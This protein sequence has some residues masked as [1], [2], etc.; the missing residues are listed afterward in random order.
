M[1]DLSGGLKM[2]LKRRVDDWVI[3]VE[4][5]LITNLHI[6]VFAL[7]GISHFIQDVMMWDSDFLKYGYLLLLFGCLLVAG[8]IEG[9]N[10]LVK[11]CG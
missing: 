3:P 6:I 11:R 1:L 4:V 7:Y 9:R 10:L 2:T 5:K 8:I